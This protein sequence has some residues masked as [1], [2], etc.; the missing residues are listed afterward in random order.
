M[1]HGALA[2]L[3]RFGEASDDAGT[4]V[5]GRF[6]TNRI[7][8]AGI[9]GE[10]IF[11]ALVLSVVHTA[12][13]TVR[14]TPIVDDVVYD[15]VSAPD[16]V[17]E[18]TLPQPLS[19]ARTWYRKEFGLSQPWVVGGTD[20]GRFALRGTWLQ[21]RIELEDLGVTIND[22]L[23]EAIYEGCDLEWAAVAETADAEPSPAVP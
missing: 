13:V 19:G 22:A 17:I 11:T 14:M 18:V 5:A 4:P 10:A 8:P 1:G 21:L 16:A 6:E 7:A 2:R 12:A 15:G 9:G 3:Y 20:R 23:G